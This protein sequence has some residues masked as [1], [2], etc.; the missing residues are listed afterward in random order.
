[1]KTVYFCCGDYRNGEKAY[2]IFKIRDIQDAFNAAEELGYDV[3][4]DSCFRFDAQ[5]SLMER[6]VVSILQTLEIKLSMIENVVACTRSEYDEAQRM[7]QHF[8][9]SDIDLYFPKFLD[10]PVTETIPGS[11]DSNTMT[12]TL[13]RRTYPWILD[14]WK[15]KIKRGEMKNIDLV[16]LDDE[17]MKMLDEAIREKKK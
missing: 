15:R 17:V 14:Y 3:V 10:T 11:V 8:M 5:S 1:M 9:N 13:A 7:K 12:V 4:L 6:M 2:R 16:V